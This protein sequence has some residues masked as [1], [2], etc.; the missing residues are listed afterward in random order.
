MGWRHGSAPLSSVEI[1]R[2]NSRRHFGQNFGIAA[3]NLGLKFRH[4]QLGLFA[5]PQQAPQEQAAR[6]RRASCVRGCCSLGDSRRRPSL[7]RVAAG[8]PPPRR[9][10]TSLASACPTAKV[11][12]SRADDHRGSCWGSL[13][14]IGK[15]KG[16]P[17]PRGARARARAARAPAASP[18]AAG[19][20]ACARSRAREGLQPLLDASHD[21]RSGL[22]G[23]RGHRVWA[24]RAGG[25][26]PPPPAAAGGAAARPAAP[27]S[28]TQRATLGPRRAGAT[29]FSNR[30]SRRARP[31][32]PHP[33]P[34]PPAAR[35]RLNSP[36]RIFLL[37]FRFDS[38]PAM[39]AP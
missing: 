11:A 29:G 20:P 8:D 15:R 21:P 1:S 23:R 14:S 39:C 18:A 25:A 30:I 2:R 16:G 13:P 4:P 17:A 6:R 19:G 9:C 35:C 34:P 37:L 27:A 36:S 5:P 12:P 22:P 10:A 31:S 24:G 3:N 26:P 33:R 32:P 28:A 7:A 38:A